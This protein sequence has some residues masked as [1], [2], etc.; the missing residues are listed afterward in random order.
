MS[1]YNPVTE[2]VLEA[3]RAA[4][5]A[6]NVK[7]DEETLDRYKTDEETDPRYHHLPEVVVLPGST[8]EVAEVMKIANKYLVPV[9][10]RSAGTSVSC[11]AVP[12]HGGIVL[13]L[14]R[15]DKIIEMNT[16]AMYMVVEA[17]A[18]TI[19]IQKMANDAGFLY[20]GDPC[21]ADSCLIGGNI[22]TN[23][24]GNKAVRYGTTRHQVYS[25]EVV[26]PT[27]EITEL[28]N[29]L[30]KC[31][32]GYCLDQLIM[33]SEGTL[34]II[35]KAT[36]KLLPMCPYK[37]DILAVFTDVQKAV[38][39]VPNLIKAG[40]NP[41]SI[42]FMDNGFVR[43]ASDFTEIRLPHYEDGSYVIVTVETFNEDELDMKMEQLDEICTQC[44][45]TDVLEADERVW[46]VRRN[47][48]EGTRVLSKVSTSDD[49]VV[50]VDKI[51]DCIEHLQEVA[52][53]YNFKLMCLAH[54]GDGNLH[55]QILKCDMSDEEWE[56]ELQRFHA[57]AYEYVYSLGGRISGEHGI[58]AKKLAAMETYTDPVELEIMRTIK[59]A[60][61]PNNI[62]NPGKVFNV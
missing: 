21:S 51:A 20:A 30:K 22:A 18:R 44:G 48:L 6:E 53:D 60:M 31:S 54:A 32:T 47:C 57:I 10:P 56:D 7:V 8:E 17:G 4:L 23:A 16:E 62:L 45:A 13:L 19:E 3:L 5:G 28:G 9:T 61:D 29:R 49:L 50:P 36:L 25:I 43:A 42:E 55:F 11:G 37:L 40:L 27:G 12:V 34:G 41:T 26:T 2:E 14:E 46:R 58:G 24:G 39:L 1:T 35:T 33:G 52:K 38:D 59:R 15:M